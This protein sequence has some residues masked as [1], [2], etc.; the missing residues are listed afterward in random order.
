MC[1]IRGLC[2][3]EPTKVTGVARRG[4]KLGVRAIRGPCDVEP[5]EV[6]GVARRGG[7]GGGSG[8]T[9]IRGGLIGPVESGGRGVGGILLPGTQVEALSLGFE[10][11]VIFMRVVICSLG[12]VYSDQ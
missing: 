5:T 10:T 7:G 8:E 11:M 1:A 9:A 6:P 4:G 2:D 3:V 12:S